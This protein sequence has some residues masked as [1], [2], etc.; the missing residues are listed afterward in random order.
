MSPQRL[1]V[2][3]ADDSAFNRRV[4]CHVV[5]R[6]DA[7]VEEAADGEEAVMWMALASFDLVLMDLHMPSMDGIEATRWIR[8]AGFEGPI[9]A[10]TGSDRAGD[11]DRCLAAGMTASLAKPFTLA[12][13]QELLAYH[14]RWAS[15]PS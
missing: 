10:T 4:S 12:Q 2:L 11:I 1:R 13:L 9:I 14:L 8:R 7:D 3:I 15:S 5:R 6:C